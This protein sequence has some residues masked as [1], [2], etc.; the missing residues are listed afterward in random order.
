MKKSGTDFSVGGLRIAPVLADSA[1]NWRVFEANARAFLA[2]DIAPGPFAEMCTAAIASPL[3]DDYGH[4][5]YKYRYLAYMALERYFEA[6]ID[7]QVMLAAY[8]DELNHLQMCCSVFLKRHN[9]SQALLCVD[10][11]LGLARKQGGEITDLLSDRASLCRFISRVK[12][13]TAAEFSRELGAD[14]AAA[15]RT[16][17]GVPV[18]ISGEALFALNQETNH[19]FLVFNLPEQDSPAAFT[20]IYGHAAQHEIP[21]LHQVFRELKPGQAQHLAML[22]YYLGSVDK[23]ILFSPCYLVS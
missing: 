9:F 13:F 4:T 19:P 14:P 6:L 15:Q 11:L 2:K 16:Y 23:Q 8:S 21:F 1:F 22:G 20:C 17:A 5:I 7:A 3:A 10:R 12:S 18:Q